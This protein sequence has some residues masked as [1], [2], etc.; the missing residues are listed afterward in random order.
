MMDVPYRYSKDIDSSEVCKVS[1]TH[2]I[3]HFQKLLPTFQGLLLGYRRQ[4][5][6][7]G[8]TIPMSQSYHFSH[9]SY[10]ILEFSLRAFYHHRSKT[11]FQRDPHCFQICGMIEVYSHRYGSAVSERT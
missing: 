6:F 1:C 7:H 8:G 10:L 11:I 2:G 5:R 4:F 3:C 9:E